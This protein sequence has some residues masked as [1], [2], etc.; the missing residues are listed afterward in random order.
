MAVAAARRSGRGA[1]PTGTVPAIDAAGSPTAVTQTS[2]TIRVVSAPLT[3]A[4]GTPTRMVYPS[5]V[6]ASTR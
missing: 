6:V 4:L 5:V 2:T 3:S 1:T